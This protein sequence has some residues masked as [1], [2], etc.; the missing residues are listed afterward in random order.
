MLGSREAPWGP[1]AGVTLWLSPKR[2]RGPSDGDGR[3][4][5][6]SSPRPRAEDQVSPGGQEGP[7]AGRSSG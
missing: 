5:G 7:R 1:H 3:K 2:G 6:R 4:H